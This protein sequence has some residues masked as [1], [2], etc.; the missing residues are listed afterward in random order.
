V[1]RKTRAIKTGA[2]TVSTH[3]AKLGLAPQFFNVNGGPAE[4]IADTTV[5]FELPI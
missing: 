2:Q 4:G 1:G 3:Y 5:I